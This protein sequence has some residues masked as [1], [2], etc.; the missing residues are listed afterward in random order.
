MPVW[1]CR[2][3]SVEHYLKF[4]EVNWLKIG[5]VVR[6]TWLRGT[7]LRGTRLQGPSQTKCWVGPDNSWF[8]FFVSK[9]NKYCSINPSSPVLKYT[10]IKI[11]LLNIILNGKGYIVSFAVKYIVVRKQSR[12]KSIHDSGMACYEHCIYQLEAPRIYFLD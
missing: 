2:S 9:S 12:K 7:W 5:Y 11:I 8:H 1:Y 3:L 10:K 6:D 4:S